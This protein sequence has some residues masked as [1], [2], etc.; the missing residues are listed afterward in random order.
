MF[1]VIGN[2]IGGKTTG[3]SHFTHYL[4]KVEAVSHNE[5]V[6]NGEPTIVTFEAITQWSNLF[7]KYTKSRV[8]AI[9]HRIHGRKLHHPL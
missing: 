1:R 3:M 7:A 2:A 5:V 4:I 8:N 6:R 9:D